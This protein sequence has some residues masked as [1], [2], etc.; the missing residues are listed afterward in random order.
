MIAIL[1]ANHGLSVRHACQVASP[2]RAACLL[3]PSDRLD[4]ASRRH[5]ETS[6]ALARGNRAG[7]SCVASYQLDWSASSRWPSTTTSEASL[8]EKDRFHLYVDNSNVLL[9]GRRL[10]QMQRKGQARRS[11]FLDDTYEIDWGKFLYLVQERGQ[12]VLANVPVLYGSRPPPDDSVW[13][14][15]RDAG[16]DTK[17]FDR[18][19]RNK[20]KGVDMEMGM[21][22]AELLHTAKPSSSIV[23][24]A[25]DADYLPA[26]KRAQAKGWRVEV[27]FWNNVAYD[28]KSAAN[29]FA[30]L[31]AHYEF[32]R[33]GGGAV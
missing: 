21:D 20:E 28:L 1:V 10:A 33:L 27:W 32:L 12:R 16:F 2:S 17:V 7:R 26:V 3:P 23:I 14:R 30:S 24:A 25:G 22:I 11:A 31:D 13:Q 18:N 19:I 4:E 9:E 5:L 15:I 8:P 29:R 6:G